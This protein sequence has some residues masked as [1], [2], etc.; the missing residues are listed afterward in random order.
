VESNTELAVPAPVIAN[1][2]PVLYTAPP[3]TAVRFAFVPP[4]LRP[5]CPETKLEF[6]R[7]IVPHTG[8]LAPLINTEFPVP[9]PNASLVRAAN[10]EPL[11]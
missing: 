4:L 9:D 6:P 10:V 8:A 2:E 3:F 7:A 5:N 11:P 1:D